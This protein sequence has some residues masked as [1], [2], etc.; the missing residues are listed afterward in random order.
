MIRRYLLLPALLF[1]LG[2]KAQ[3]INY[4]RSWD[5]RIPIT[6][7]STMNTRP[8]SEVMQTTAYVDGLGRP[9]QTVVKQ[10]SL[11]TTTSVSGD[12]VSYN[13]YD[14]MGRELQ[15]YLPYAAAAADGAFKTN[16]VTEQNS[17]NYGQYSAQGDSYFYSLTQVESSP[18]NRAV[19][20]MS[21]GNSWVGASRGSSIQYV[22][23]T[24]ADDVKIWTVN[25]SGNYTISGSPYG[26]GLLTET[27]TIDEN[28]KQVVEYK[29]KEGK[30]LLKKVQVDNTIGDSYDGWLCT[31]YLYDIYN[32]LRLVI[33]PKAI[34]LLRNNSWTLTTAIL[35]ELCFR[36]EY[37]GK[38]RMSIKKVP[39]AAEVYMVYDK[40]DRLVLTQDGNLRSSNK[41]IFNKYDYLNRPV[42]TGFYT[43]T[44]NTTQAGM[45]GLADAATVRY[46]DRN[47][48][49]V[50]YTTSNSFPS[51]SSSALLSIT[52][53]DDYNWTSNYGTGYTAKDNSDDNLFYTTGSSPLYAQPLTQSNLTRG[54]PTGSVTYILNSAAN[55]K[56]ISAVFYDAKGRA[57]QSKTSNIS[58]GIDVATTQYNFSGQPL[59][60]ITAHK[61]TSSSAVIKVITKNEYDALGRLLQVKKQVQ[62]EGI[63]MPEK[64]IVKN[65]YDALGQLKN[66]IL[67][68]EFNSNAG[69]EKLN[70]EYNVRGWLLGVNRD[71]IKDINTSNY[72]GFE[73][74]Y[75]KTAT[76]VSGTSYTN[77]QY[78]GN[79]EGTVW[80]S[81]GDNEKRKY[82]FTYDNVNRLLAA[83]FNQ[84]TNGGFTKYANVDFSVKMGDGINYNAAYD[85]NG[86]ILQM[87]QWGL[88]INNSEQIDDLHY[89][90]YNTATNNGSNKLQS[91]IDFKELP[92]SKL[93][94]FKTSPNH[95]QYSAKSAITTQTAFNSN[96]SSIYDYGYDING[97]MITDRN[98]DISGATG[99][100][101]TTGGAITYNHLNLPWIITV[102]GKGNITYSYDAAGNKLQ[103]T[104]TENNVSIT[105]NNTAYTA[106][107]VITTTDYV[108]GFVYES[109]SYSNSTLHTALGYT[110]KLQFTGH[111]EG[112]IRANYTN[113]AL[114]NTIT[115]FAFDYMVKDHLGNVRMVLTDG[116]QVD[117]YPTATVEANALTQEQTFYDIP[118]PSVTVVNKPTPLATESSTLLD[119]INDN[120]TNNPN[121]FGTP[122]ATSLK[123]MKL[124]A[125]ANKTGM[126]MVLK[127]MAGD[128]LDILGKSY[129]QYTGGT[130]TNS[131]FN[132]GS[133][134][135][136]F[137]AVGSGNNAAVLHGGTSTILNTNTSGTVTPLN[138]FTNNSS[139]T[140]PYNNVKAGV[141]Y[142]LFD[143]QFNLVSCQFNPVYIKLPG[144]KGGAGGPDGGFKDHIM[145][146]INVPKNGY[147]YVY[148]S[149]ES[150][151][152]VFF[153]NLEVIHTR[154]AILEETHY[155]PF[156]LTM[157]GISSKAAEGINNRIK[158]NGKE[159]QRQEFSDGSGLEWLDYGA[160]MYDNQIGRWNTIDLLSEKY[161]PTN[162]Y[163]Y[164]M[165]N[166]ILFIDPDG[167]RVK[168]SNEGKKIAEGWLKEVGLDKAF[169]IKRNGEIKARSSFK[170][171]SFNGDTKKIEL[172]EGFKAVVNE[173]E[174]NLKVDVVNSIQWSRSNTERTTT[175]KPSEYYG[176][177]VANG[178]VVEE[179]KHGEQTTTE[180]LIT[181]ENSALLP[182]NDQNDDIII[183]QPKENSGAAAFFH[184]V[185]D[186][187]IQYNEK[188]PGGAPVKSPQFYENLTRSI[189]KLGSDAAPRN[190]QNYQIKPIKVTKSSY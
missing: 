4:V 101:Q 27:H 184:F 107:T 132:A 22:N 79:I 127:V 166:P 95:T 2:A 187:G 103:K 60:N 49:T 59:M 52:Y 78:N 128:K 143:E 186:L 1:V 11:A 57:I 156:G 164:A 35:N 41:W 48:T 90:Y 16:A 172:Y 3:S 40:W 119:Y 144:V 81:K 116:Q 63:Q 146:D 67:S 82:D 73:L 46:E 177:S 183:V 21:P 126:S 181:G 88:K 162:P 94:D 32:N 145:Q 45:Q 131:T 13:V 153:D 178:S 188:L 64:A 175:E 106:I 77:P 62:T 98:K 30:V 18:L 96:G 167:K 149:N 142:I 39:G 93:G 161:Y 37:D 102:A 154:G 76:A 7:A 53:Y 36:Y 100:D 138:G 44:T 14:D 158:Y 114:P 190:D 28:G 12:I 189:M 87:Q 65:E 169:K 66:K 56:I 159:E 47:S 163:N 8:V 42:L 155:Y 80:K 75:D 54:M 148:C 150:N 130:V 182:Q 84:Y 33:Q 117:H 92:V 105:H 135:T 43:N 113:T 168:I 85:E 137:L 157:A 61:K 151:I 20:N 147:L 133:I 15:K 123:M 19:K 6:D 152:D 139:N 99:I 83:D 110:D 129:Y 180:Y 111:E 55:D 29:D 141:C 50:G 58:G 112:R 68:P 170:T 115:A 179:R 160:R 136:A 109:K 72:F 23:N 173:K 125:A 24:T 74:G 97:N 174:N 17:F 70:Y 171:S 176:I 124:N 91:V 71:F 122:S 108:A 9:M 10:G 89:S 5:A 104:T 134:I 26:D 118:N 51:V 38:N 120:G 165:N 86:N 185:V 69:L 31:Y 140:N 34:T 121:T 25:G